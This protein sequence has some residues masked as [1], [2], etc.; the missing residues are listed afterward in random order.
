M[1]SR[2]NK[3]Q[4]HGHSQPTPAGQEQPQQIRQTIPR[5]SVSPYANN[6]GQPQ[7]VPDNMFEQ[8]TNYIQSQSRRQGQDF[9][10]AKASSQ[11]LHHFQTEFNPMHFPIQY[12][13]ATTAPFSTVSSVGQF[14]GV[15]REEEYSPAADVHHLHHNSHHLMS[16]S[17]PALIFQLRTT[18]PKAWQTRNN[19][20]SRFAVDAGAIQYL[21]HPRPKLEDDPACQ[22]SSR[23]NPHG[24]SD[25]TLRY[26]YSAWYSQENPKIG[27]L[28]QY[29]LGKIP[30]P[31]RNAILHQ[32]DAYTLTPSQIYEFVRCIFEPGASTPDEALRGTNR[33]RPAENRGDARKSRE[34]T[35]LPERARHGKDVDSEETQDLRYVD[36]EEADKLEEGEIDEKVEAE[37]DEISREDELGMCEI[38]YR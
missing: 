25:L 22:M 19:E 33:N 5:G 2:R 20:P 8:A 11:S 1:I 26:M 36:R 10:T 23:R 34:M 31:V 29:M 28:T 30:I 12:L 13:P 24:Q 21:V 17:G 7:P 27:I 3:H 6:Q 14:P 15:Y 37:E 35:P 32:Y 4:P 9:A 18:E 38:L 16:G